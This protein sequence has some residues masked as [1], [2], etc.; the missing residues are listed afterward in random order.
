[1]VVLSPIDTTERDVSFSQFKPQFS[2]ANFLD[3]GSPCLRSGRLTH[4]PSR[5]VA[6]PASVSAATAP[7]RTAAPYAAERRSPPR[8]RCTDK[9]GVRS[10]PRGAAPSRRCTVSSPRPPGAVPVGVQAPFRCAFVGHHTT[11]F[12]TRVPLSWCSSVHDEVDV[13]V[14]DRSYGVPIGPLSPAPEVS[15]RGGNS[16]R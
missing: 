3:P 4:L 6:A 5:A 16:C 13:V 9:C 14:F 10:L 8:R 12:R 15:V 1:M 2:E 7:R 11:D